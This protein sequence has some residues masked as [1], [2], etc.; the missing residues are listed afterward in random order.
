MFVFSFK[1]SK[2]KLLAISLSI[3]SI[4]LLS[5]SILAKNNTIPTKSNNKETNYT[6]TNN[7]ERIEFL[8]KFG[9][10]VSAEAIEISDISI[11]FEFNQ[12]Y[13]NY[14]KIQKEQG[15]D[16]SKYKGQKVKRWTYEIKNYSATEKN[17]VANILTINDTVIGGDI[18]SKNLDGFMHG[19]RKN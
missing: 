4:V 6:V 15:F 14:N 11:P 12:V 3:L 7:D 17:V 19:F 16:L 18:S 9:W 2:F 13:E 8:K 10:D 5:T 1:M